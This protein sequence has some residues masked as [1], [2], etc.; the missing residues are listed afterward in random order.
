MIAKLVIVRPREDLRDSVS[1]YDE[2][3]ITDYRKEVKLPRV[4][5]L[6]GTGNY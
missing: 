4:G 2:P 5:S 1:Q 6:L 3:L